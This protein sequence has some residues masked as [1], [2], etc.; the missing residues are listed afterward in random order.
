MHFNDIDDDI[1][2]LALWVSDHVP[3]FNDA[4]RLIQSHIAGVASDGDY[5]PERSS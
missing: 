5:F 4:A 2:D 3:S 1:I